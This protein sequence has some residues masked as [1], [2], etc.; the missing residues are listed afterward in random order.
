MFA[1][2][3]LPRVVSSVIVFFGLVILAYMFAHGIAF[4]VR[5]RDPTGKLTDSAEVCVYVFICLY[6]WQDLV[7]VRRKL[8][9]ALIPPD[10]H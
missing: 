6:F 10:E 9:A 4:L 7:R 5:L 1:S 2:R 3:I 8:E